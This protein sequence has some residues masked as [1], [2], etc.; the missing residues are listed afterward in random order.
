MIRKKIL[1]VSIN[2]CSNPFPVYPI[3]LS[4]LA[5]F[6]ESRLAGCEIR[7]FDFLMDDISLF[8]TSLMEFTPDLVGISL[9]NIDTVNILDDEDFVYKHKDIIGIIRQISTAKIVMGG[10]GFSIF[11]KEIFELYQPDF[12]IFGEGENSLYQLLYCLENN[13]PLSDVEGLIYK[14]DKNFYINQRKSYCYE[15]NLEY[16][17]ELID[18]YWNISGMISLQTKR[19]CPYDCI[20][21]TYPLID[22]RKIR[23]LNTDKIVNAIKKLY[24]QKGIDYFFFT[25][26]V[27]NIKNSYNMELAEKI[28][29]NGIKIQWGAYFSPH[30]LDEHLLKKLKKSGLTHIEFGTE[31]ICDTTLQNYRKSFRVKDVLETSDLCSRVGVYFAHFMIL[32]GYGETEQTLIETFKNS[33]KIKR[34]VFFPFLGMRIYPRTHLYEYAVNEGV[35]NKKDSLIKPKYYVA[36]NMD[37]DRMKALAY[38]TGKQWIF[39]DEDMQQ[40]ITKMRQKGI[41]GPLW[42][43]L[44]K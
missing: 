28:I 11:P 32:G 30:N 44:I 36:K 37:W 9:R 25:D 27:F 34:T 29:S 22:G 41:K 31:S 38:E 23:T 24:H 4:Y 18:Y 43:F 33:K 17:D 10:A 14:N 21:C 26:S 5:T 42:E 16:K 1:L 8:K 39:P 7:L 20:Y 19:G 35:I 3:A 6:L 15:P 40:P 2:Q 13:S 12:G